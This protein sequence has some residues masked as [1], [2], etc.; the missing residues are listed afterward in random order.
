[1]SKPIYDAIVVGSGAGGATAAYVLVKRGL[2]VLLLEAGRMLDQAK[3]FN[4]HTWPYELKFRG[5]GN[6][7]EYDGLWKINEYTAH[8]YTNPRK[9]KY[10]ADPE[11]HWTRL[12]A[13]GGRTNTWGRSCYRHGPMDFKTKTM[14]GFGEDWPISYEDLAPYY[15]KAERLVGI[16]GQKENY[17]NM[18]D[19]VYAAPAHKPRCTEFHIKKSAAKLGVPVVLE[20]TAVLSAPYDGR[21]GCHY[22]GACG[23]GCDVRAR[24]SSLDV[25]I[26][27]LQAK[28]NFTLRTHAVAH[29]VLVDNNGRARGV[30][31][32]DARTK[33]HYEVAA[34]AVVLA[35]STVE[36]GRIL[37]NSTSRFHPRG[38]GNSSGLV[39]H[40]L[41]DSVKSGGLG[42]L[43][44]V[45]KN[46]E[47]VNEDGAGGTHI[48]IPRFNY[49]RKQD[50]HGGYFI[51]TGSGFDRRPARAGVPGFGSALKGQ[52]RE[53]YGSLITLRGYGERL[54]AYDNYFELDPDNVDAYGIPQV[55]F[56]AGEKEND[57]RMMEDMF[58][59]ME[60]IMRAAGA[61]VLPYRKYL[62]PLGD[63]THECGTARM[64][65]DPKTS[66]LNQ[67]CQ[68]HEVKNL[69]VTDGSCF[70]SLPGTHGITTW[71]MALA[72]RAS[73][74]LAEQ[75]KRGEL[76]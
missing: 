15:D 66:V 20:R 8:L 31:V 64:G 3:D 41:M 6:P 40:Y 19:G 49:N 72:W 50:F 24:F 47:R 42:G 70:V 76:G 54:P 35:A 13:V 11:F 56:H 2:N 36:S 63:A 30:S 55:R 4:T 57:R 73:D 21:P 18:P 51:L 44:P 37:L 71:I 9:D 67:Y 1:M 60:Q 26:P 39:G 48:T 33:R 46:R 52:I 32:F 65:N 17:L 62:E 27:K 23:N 58:G 59:W 43:V 29:Q 69:F 7:G 5:R 25:I 12:R 10:A 34:K 14:Q 75:M 61:E 45:L 74:Y 38:L 22:C 16:S 68:S 53:E 28:R